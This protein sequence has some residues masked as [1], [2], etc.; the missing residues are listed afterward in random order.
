MIK[1]I[2]W[3]AS[4]EAASTISSAEGCLDQPLKAKCDL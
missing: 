3:N 2:F 4:S 1:G